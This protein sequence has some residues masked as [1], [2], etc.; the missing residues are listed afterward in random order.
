MEKELDIKVNPIDWKARYKESEE[1]RWK[2]LDILEE[3]A[4]RSCELKDKIKELE[5]D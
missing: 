5:N 1:K 2:M 3:V 4:A